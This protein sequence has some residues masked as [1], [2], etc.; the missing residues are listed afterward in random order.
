MF[1]HRNSFYWERDKIFNQKQRLKKLFLS[2][3]YK[4]T[5]SQDLLTFVIEVRSCSKNSQTN[6]IK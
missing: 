3:D 6:Q 4:N 5:S 1:Q 2:Y